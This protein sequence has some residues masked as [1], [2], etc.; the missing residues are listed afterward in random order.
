MI[1]L[2]ST[3]VLVVAALVAIVGY[4]LGAYRPAHQSLLT[5]GTERFT[6]SDIEARTLYLLLF[7]QSIA[8]REAT[9]LIPKALDVLEHEAILRQRAPALV[10]DVSAEDMAKD[11]A[12]RLA[13]PVPPTP[14]PTPS[15]TLGTPTPT[16]TPDATPTATA[17]ATAAPKPTIDEKQVASTQQERLQKSGLSKA[18]FDAL[19]R[20]Q[21]LED[22][23]VKRYTDEAPKTA[24]QWEVQVAILP[25]VE[26]AEQLRAIV[27]RPGV[28][29][30]RVA[31]AAATDSS[32]GQLAW[33]LADLQEPEVR[34]ALSKL[35]AGEISATIKSGTRYKVYRLSQIE[36]NRTVDEEQRDNAATE[37]LTKWYE[38]ER[39]ALTIE[40]DVVAS[41]DAAMRVN[42]SRAYEKVQP[43]K[44]AP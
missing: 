20:A 23:L 22:R 29:F 38:D 40:R 21:I 4:Y 7:Q 17:T 19:T 15:I 5:A 35:K 26:R 16:G 37:R 2:A 31:S 43:V 18:A 39:K 34:D 27:Q 14:I 9:E 1:V 24:L 33:V 10:G 32:N 42:I 30:A 41:R 44:R 3:V 6:A 13:T 28:D 25:S 36:Q 11:L 12:V 8:P